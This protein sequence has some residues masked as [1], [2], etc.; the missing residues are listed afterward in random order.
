MTTIRKQSIISSGVVYLGFGLGAITN[1]ILIRE[2]TPDQYGL[3]SGMFLAIGMVLYSF[4]NLGMPSVVN[5]FYPYYRAHLPPK[6]ND[7]LT[8][9]LLL[10]LT[11]CVLVAIGGIFFRSQVVHYYQSQSPAFVKYYY[12]IF[13][14]ALGLTVY[15]LLEYYAWQLKKSILTNYLR[16]VQF[17]VTTLVLLIL[18]LG[19]VIRSFGIVIKLYAFNYLLIALILIVYL[20]R[21]GEFHLVFSRSLVTKKFSRRMR[22]LAL[23]SW[24]GG[25]V[26]NIAFFFAQIVIAA[27]VPAGLTAVGVF[28]MAQFAGSLVQA[29]QRAL[30]AA[31]T[32]PLSQAWKDKDHGRISRIYRRSSITQLIFSVGMFLLLLINFRDG[33]ITFGFP[34]Q[35]LMARPA[36]IFIGLARIVDMGTGVNGQIIATSTRWRFDFL[37]GLVLAALTLP[38]NYVLA[39]HMGL[40]GPAVADLG[41][42]AIYN[43]IRW[44]FLYRTFK[45]QPF[46]IHTLYSLLLGGA[47]FLLCQ[48]AFG[49]RHGLLWLFA[50]SISFLT[51]YGGGVV[52][53]N[54]SEDIAPV[55]ATI[56]K[57]IKALFS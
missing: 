9:A 10:L 12:W 20:V 26:Y 53:L 11:G 39:K 37:S 7:L 48:F 47:G 36:F 8:W 24:S 46:T 50:R 29:P 13:P 30:V 4:A 55:W 1:I 56:R 44:A 15:T 31:S 23:L 19:G 42:F 5:K 22:A 33:I 45:L 40:L 27:V 51:I 35:Y 17:R 34:R 25:V 57:R 54:L 2:F 49:N 28:Q 6:K 52:A 38:L 18:Y 41:T 14:F 43:G 21:S 32:G 3:I 16:E